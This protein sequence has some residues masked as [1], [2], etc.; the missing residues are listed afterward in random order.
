MS[1]T[2]MRASCKCCL[3]SIRV[4][5]VSGF[6][7]ER[8]RD[9][10]SRPPK[11]MCSTATAEP[12]IE[13]GISWM[14][15]NEHKWCTRDGQYIS[16][17]A[18]QVGE[19][20]AASSPPLN[21]ITI[22]EIFKWQLKEFLKLIN[23]QSRSLLVS[24]SKI[25]LLRGGWRRCRSWRRRYSDGC[26]LMDVLLP[27]ASCQPFFGQLEMAFERDIISAVCEKTLVW[28][29]WIEY[30]RCLDLEIVRRVNDL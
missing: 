2:A 12:K 27:K 23:V 16:G 6:K 8:C 21:W 13:S 4:L 24:W 15:F 19:L 17:K 29:L 1:W 7:L 9:I 25:N 18:R 10:V 28:D 26:W 14:V 30:C 22:F 3:T 11:K 5:I 20:R